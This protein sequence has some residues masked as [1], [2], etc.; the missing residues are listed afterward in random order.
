[1]KKGLA[2]G[3]DEDM[4]DQDSLASIVFILVLAGIFGA[5]VYY[6]SQNPSQDSQTQSPIAVRDLNDLILVSSPLPD[7]EITSPLIVEGRARGIW[8][9]EAVFPVVLMN[10]NGQV[11]AGS[12]A[13][14]QS[15]WMTEDFI[16]FRAELNFKLVPGGRGTIILKNN[17]PSGLAQNSREL[18]IPVVFPEVENEENSNKTIAVKVFFN[19][20]NFQPEFLE[21]RSFPTERQIPYTQSVA[22]AAVEE[23]LKGPTEQEKSEGFFTNINSGVKVRSLTIDNGIA[24]VDFT[25]ELDF[26]VAGS[27]RVTAIRDQITQTLK[28]FPTVKDVIIS[29]NGR[30]EDILQP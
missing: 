21:I 12:L 11:L 26:Q 6:I 30:T 20:E 29:I 4:K 19:N 2:F 7:Q 17:N 15:D 5:G 13:T 28:Q 8:F 18:K 10:Q 27:A 22:R 1:M 14:T 16:N 25:P 3:S 9:F 24:R 23:L